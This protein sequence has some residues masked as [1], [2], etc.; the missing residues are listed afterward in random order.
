MTVVE[1][2][3]TSWDRLNDLLLGLKPG[4]S[5]TPE[6]LIAATGLSPET[7]RT[8]LEALTRAGLFEKTE[9]HTFIRR[10]LYGPF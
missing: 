3:G 8:V 2:H 1:T 5:V 4:D 7:V 10:R 9:Q 6:D